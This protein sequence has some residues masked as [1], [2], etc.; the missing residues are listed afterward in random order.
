M[1]PARDPTKPPG[2][3][4]A[5][6][7]AAGIDMAVNVTKGGLTAG[8]SARALKQRANHRSCQVEAKY[9]FWPHLQA[10]ILP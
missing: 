10:R 1:R 9:K 3:G 5:G 8:A 7:S 6:Q 2:M 4:A